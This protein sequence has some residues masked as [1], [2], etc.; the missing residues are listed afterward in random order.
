MAHPGVRRDPKTGQLQGR[1]AVD[2]GLNT[3]HLLSGFL[4]CGS[5]GGNMKLSAIS[6]KANR[7][8]KGFDC[9]RY[10]QTGGSKLPGCR[11]SIH[12]EAITEAVRGALD[13]EVIQREVLAY[14]STITLTDPD[15]ERTRLEADLAKAEK[16]ADNLAN[17]IGLGGDMPV[18]V[19]KLKAATG[20]VEA[21]RASLARQQAVA[22][23]WQE[24]DPEEI[25]AELRLAQEGEQEDLTAER[26]VLRSLGLTI[27]V[28]RELKEALIQGNVSNI[29]A[30]RL[31][32]HF[33]AQTDFWKWVGLVL[34]NRLGAFDQQLASFRSAG[35]LSGYWKGGL[36][37]HLN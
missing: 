5:C 15:I 21:L 3:K 30:S 29:V 36:K 13:P 4:R 32:S 35:E 10:Y 28:D 23:H 17:A 6:H 24:I 16:E 27:T 26:Q 9:G 19:A 7:T 34:L 20:R 1:V 33:H 11:G 12:Y 25:A 14:L 8:W 18:L 22:D 2:T 31:S 37:Q